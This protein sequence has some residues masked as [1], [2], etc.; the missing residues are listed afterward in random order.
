MSDRMERIISQSELARHV[1]LLILEDRISLETQRT[2]MTHGL[3]QYPN[4]FFFLSHDD[5][6]RL[7]LKFPFA[8]TPELVAAQNLT[9]PK[10]SPNFLQTYDVDIALMYYRQATTLLRLYLNPQNFNIARIGFVLFMVEI[11]LQRYR[12]A[13]KGEV[14]ARLYK[15]RNLIETS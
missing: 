4:S 14:Y 9:Q 13:I 5:C 6:I 2:L 8:L 3:L 12:D 10:V 15:K 1:M 11:T 7:C